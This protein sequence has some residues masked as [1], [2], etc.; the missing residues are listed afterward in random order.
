MGLKT[1]TIDFTQLSKIKSLFLST[2]IKKYNQ[3]YSFNYLPLSYFLDKKNKFTLGQIKK[4]DYQA[5]GNFPVIDQSQEFI[6]GYSDEDDLVYSGNLPVIVFGD[7]TRTFKY[8]DFK[9]IQGADGIKIIKPN[10]EIVNPKFFYYLMAKISVPS[11]GYNRHFSILK[12]QKYPLIPKSTQ[13][14]IVAQ[15]EL[16]EKKI[17]ELKLQIRPPQEIINEVFARVFGFDLEKFE[18][19]EKQKFFEVDFSEFNDYKLRFNFKSNNKSIKF[20]LKKIHRNSIQLKEILIN[21]IISGNTPKYSPKGNYRVVKTIN[22]NK[23]GFIELFES[24]K[25]I[26]K[27]NIFLEKNNILVTTHG[28][29][30][31][32]FGIYFAEEK[33][34]TDANCAI[35]KIDTNKINVLYLNYYF[36]SFIGKKL[37]NY[38]ESETKSVRY[39]KNED[40]EN[41]PIIIDNNKQQ[42]IVDEI[43]TELD[44]QEEIKNEIEQESNKI[45]EIIEKA[46]K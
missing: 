12:K 29:G 21:K 23:N 38:L 6:A 36:N 3:K 26:E 11:R 1:F 34:T 32:K 31:S 15:I 14:Q 16:I 9:F 18:E 40:L 2:R 30:R 33:A 35:I 46:I 27:T 39:M 7:H 42:R 17:K 22:V 13:D 25:Y 8:V 19:T 45:N 4:E 5:E 20:L 24:D 10:E 28:E 41:M 44:K 37:F 43:K